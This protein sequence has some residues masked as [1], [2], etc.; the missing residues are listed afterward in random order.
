M[1]KQFPPPSVVKKK[2][3]TSCVKFIL[4][5]VWLLI[6]YLTFEK[7]A[8]LELRMYTYKGKTKIVL[9]ALVPGCL[10]FQTCY[11]CFFVLALIYYN[12]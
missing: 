9:F 4:N 7:S 2:D 5:Y 8:F 6:D 3:Y 11:H 1:R 10:D 12:Q